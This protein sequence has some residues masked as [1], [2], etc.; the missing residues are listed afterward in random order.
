MSHVCTRV[1]RLTC[2]HRQ[3][4]LDAAK[5]TQ[6]SCHASLSAPPA[7]SASMASTAP[8]D[9]ATCSG[10]PRPWRCIAQYCKNLKRSLT[11]TSCSVQND[12]MQ[13]AIRQYSEGLSM[14]VSPVTEAE[15]AAWNAR[16]TAQCCVFNYYAIWSM[17]C[18]M[19]LPSLHATEQLAP[20]CTPV[21]SGPG[22]AAVL[23]FNT[24]SVFAPLTMSARTTAA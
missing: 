22:T 23:T 3:L 24:V 14:D 9:A 11:T 5:L 1:S 19:Q 15:R 13:N 21:R 16:R 18:P 10:V 6:M 17:F 7:I 12:S 8:A 4:N 20:P 2:A